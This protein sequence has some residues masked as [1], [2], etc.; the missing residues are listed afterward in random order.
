MEAG[1]A[2]IAPWPF[3]GCDP[4]RERLGGMPDAAE[5]LGDPDASVTIVGPAIN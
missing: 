5:L 3:T 4:K 1:V 2:E